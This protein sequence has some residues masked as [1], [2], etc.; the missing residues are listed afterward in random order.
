LREAADDY[1]RQLRDGNFE[2]AFHGLIELDP[3][4]VPLLI[5]AYRD[6]GSADVR[7]DLLRI[8]WEFRT[9]SV[10]PLLAEVLQDRRGRAWR[11]ALGG[12]VTLGSPEAIQVLE[13]ALHE[14]SRLPNPDLEYIEWVR[15]ALEQTREAYADK[16][17]GSG[18]EDSVRPGK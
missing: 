16:E 18:E 2:S 11:G 13:T 17:P 15:E 9:P 1:L 7:S 10:L 12:L 4:I 6:E 8:I 5:A 3:A 14:E